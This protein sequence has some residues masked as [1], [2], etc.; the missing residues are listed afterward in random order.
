M[1][2]P[3]LGKGDGEWCKFCV[4]GKGCG[5]YEARP[6]VCQ[7]FKCIYLEAHDM[8]QPLALE[9]RPDKCKVMISGTTDNNCVAAFVDGGRPDAWRRDDVLQLISKLAM[10]GIYVIVGVSGQTKRRFFYKKGHAVHHRWV[11]MGPPDETGTQYVISD[12]SFLKGAA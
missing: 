10:G 2:I 1:A 12:L 9:L 5:Q 6:P 7:N 3:E 11:E 8:G 4:V